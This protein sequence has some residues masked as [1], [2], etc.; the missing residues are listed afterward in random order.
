MSR[1]TKASRREAFRRA[2]TLPVRHTNASTADG[3][4]LFGALRGIRVVYMPV[5]PELRVC[6]GSM[7]A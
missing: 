1:H 2:N 7:G 4:R 3:R 6:R 5:Y